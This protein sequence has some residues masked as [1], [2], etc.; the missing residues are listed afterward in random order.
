MSIVGF[1][2]GVSSQGPIAGGPVA[3]IQSAAMTG[4]GGVAPLAMVGG[5]VG[6]VG[7]AVAM[8]VHMITKDKMGEA[9]GLRGGLWV[10]GCE[11]GTGNVQFFSRELEADARQVFFIGGSTRRILFQRHRDGEWSEHGWEGCHPESDAAIRLAL[12]GR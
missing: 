7:G 5:V 6:V 4:A 3:L 1:L 10:V 8:A 2:F 12:H 11:R 9:N